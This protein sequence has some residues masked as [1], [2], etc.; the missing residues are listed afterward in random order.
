[1]IFR[2]SLSKK[3]GAAYSFFSGLSAGFVPAVIIT[4]VQTLL[5]AVVPLINFINIDF[6]DSDYA[7]EKLLS[8]DRYKF[9]V[10]DMSDPAEFYILFGVLGILAILVA[11]RLFSFICDKKTVNVFYSLGIKRSTLFMSKYCAGVV[12]LIG[13]AII[14]VVLSYAVNLI[15]LGSSWQMSLVM[16]H[17]Y[18]GLSVFSLI[19]FSVAS[20]VFSSVGTVSEAVV[21]SVALLF[22]PTIII[23]LTERIIGAFLPSSTL[24]AWIQDFYLTD[25]DYWGSNS[26]SLLESTS[27]YNPLLFFAKEISAFARGF[28][29]KG[30][31]TLR[32]DKETA[33]WYIPKLF[34]HFPWFIIAAGLGVLGSLLFKR[35]KAENCGFLNTNKVL[36][37]LTIFELCL[38]GSSVLLS[39]IE[40]TEK[41]VI[42]AA[43]FGAAFALYLIAEIFL[44]RNFMKI[45]KALYKFVIHMTVVCLIYGVCMTGAFG[46]SDYIPDKSK[47][48]SVELS[49]PVSY[50]RIGMSN[51]HFNWNTNDIVYAYEPTFFR[52]LPAMKDSEDI[53]NILE[54]NR[55]IVEIE[56]D[57]D[58]ASE[59]V[60]R[61]NLKNGKTS[62]RR[63]T[64]TSRDEIY[65][66]LKLTD[67]KGFK[68]EIYNF[69]YNTFTMEDLK[70]EY[71]K[72]GYIDE[73]N[74]YNLAFTYKY[75]V[76]TARSTSLQ[77]NRV[78]N[79][80]EEQ[81]KTLKDAVYKDISSL[82]YEDYYL[83]NK[84]QKGILSFG[85]NSDVYAQLRG[86][87][88]VYK[89]TYTEPVTQVM[90][91]DIIV[92][93][94]KKENPSDDIEDE[95]IFDDEPFLEESEDTRYLYIDT[96]QYQGLGGMRGEDKSYDLIITE[97]MVN[98]LN[99]LNSFGLSDCFNSE[100]EIESVS[101]REYDLNKI[102]SYYRYSTRNYMFDFYSYPVFIDDFYYISDD[103]SLVESSVAE[104]KI[105]DKEKIN[106][107]TSL[108]KLHEYTFNDGY[109]CLVKYT[110]GTYNVKYLSRDDAP[111]FV[112]NYKY[113]LNDS[114]SSY[115]W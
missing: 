114:D 57:D 69:I 79:L 16:L 39:E 50:S 64:L 110:D 5:M 1:M 6:G 111:D 70:A 11:I 8:R 95:E 108:M 65:E 78:L 60:I 27:D 66:L 98:T 35:I 62:E 115:Y 109:L 91:P 17:M 90:M 59:I 83:S 113:T 74:A 92:E 104:N 9:F 53:D 54:F 36:S 82:S 47:I 13:A 72:Y 61:Y 30:E 14:P 96:M 84:T 31:L 33:S 112:K 46:Y 21:Y 100:L 44:K 103:I 67:L 38:L 94:D 71:N 15:F 99:A 43:G 56:D 28:I 75:S 3:K 51:M 97:D 32:I 89:M 88:S 10:F 76:V 41:S 68:D 22:A 37:N 58:F 81:F 2:K 105:T 26:Q 25:H 80:T 34:I 24:N 12:L 77:E 18:C 87:I 20:V 4:L 29:E 42:A 40:W 45:L 102:F 55:K 101:F 52:L 93:E 19:C 7:G 63:H 49:I 85:I 23:F 48:E 106:T 86:D 107:L 73:S